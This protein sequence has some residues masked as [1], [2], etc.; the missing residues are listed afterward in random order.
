MENYNDN[1]ILLFDGVCNFCNSTVNFIIKRDKKDKFRFASLQS[2][3]GINISKKFNINSSDLD[4]MILIDN[5]VIFTR[6]SAALRVNLYLNKLYPLLYG[7]IIV[8]SFIRDAAYNY[9]AKHRYKWFGKAES[10][11]IPDEKV[12]SKFISS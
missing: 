2:E 10:C 6:S 4:T 7:F 5:G 8:P 9:F 11:M 3:Q 1:V 12:R